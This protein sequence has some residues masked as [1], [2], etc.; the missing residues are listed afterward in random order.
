MSGIDIT[1]PEIAAQ[2]DYERNGD[3]KPSDVT[4]GS[5]KIAWFICDKTCPYGCPH[6]YESIISNRARLG[7][8]CP[9]C[10]SAPKKICIHMSIV[11]THPEIAAEWD[12]GKNGNLK[13]SDVTSGSD[14][15]I[16]W[17]C[18]KTCLFGCKHEYDATVSNRCN[19][20]KGCP[21]C[22]IP[23]KKNCIH[24]SIQTTHPGIACEWDYLVNGNLK[25]SDF[26]SGS[27]KIIGWKCEKNHN[28]NAA[29][30]S[31]CGAKHGC[32]H[33]LNKTAAKL[34]SYIKIHFPDVKAEFRA[35]WCQSPKTKRNLPFD[36]YIPS[37]KLVIELDGAQHFRQVRNWA[38]PLDTIKKDVYKMKCATTQ[39]ISV[40]RL[41]QEDVYANDESWLNEHLKPEL[42]LHEEPIYHLLVSDQDS[43]IYNEHEKLLAEDGMPV[44]DSPDEETA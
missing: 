10:S 31:R 32:P 35:K 26:T 6:R 34:L 1:H 22:S 17:N 19:G 23:Q 16:S 33:C 13:P 11:F 14:K 40:I 30:Y 24:T 39:G 15:K 27:G 38:I 36:F 37:L 25:P 8:G 7:Q 4:A 9:Y 5:H 44:L 41:L 29:I 18:P 2:W 42:F 43:D 20:N 21:Y 28:W 12:Y 3:L